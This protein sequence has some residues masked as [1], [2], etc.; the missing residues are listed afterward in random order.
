MTEMMSNREAY[1]R[2]LVSL[3]AENPDVVVLEADLGISTHTYLFGE[4]FPERFFEMGIA[5]GNMMGFAAGL[6][7]GG[8][9]PYAS[10]FCVFASMRACEQVRNSIAYPKL[11]VKIVATNAGIEIGPDGVTH[12]A[13]EDI[14]VMRAI[15]EMTV[16]VPSDP[17]MT[18]KLTHQAADYAGPMYVRIGRQPT[19]TLYSDDLSFEFGQAIT[20]R[21]GDDVTL[22][23][24][25][26]MVCRALQAAEILAGEGVSARV[27]DMHTVK[28]IDVAT[29]VKAAEETGCIVTTEDHNILG[30]LGGAVAEVLSCESPAP[31]VRVGLQDT[32][33]QSGEADELLEFYGLTANHIAAAARKV[34]KRR[35]G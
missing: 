16:V 32:F 28:P 11:N 5:E 20:L 9:I 17:V 4:R 35:D 34:M 2:A 1:G 24:V 30:G 8:K 19:P 21:E 33:A 15:P 22:I 31:L 14:A 12:Q 23:A 13:I 10:T 29:L 6:A 18:T 3:G 26:N 7:A 25:G 27:L